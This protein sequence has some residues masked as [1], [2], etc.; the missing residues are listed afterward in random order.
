MNLD[1]AQKRTVADWIA[2]GQKLS[3]I[4]KRLADELDIHLTYVEVRMLV[5]DLKLMP[6]DPEPVKQAEL[7]GKSAS[8]GSTAL[9]P[10]TRSAVAGGARPPEGDLLSP[11]AG[12]V[13]VKVDQLARPDALVSG[14]VTFSDGH[15]AT[16]YL[17]QMGRL[18]LAPKQQGY[19]P[20]PPDL[21]AFQAELQNELA[22][23]G[24]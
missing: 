3:E 11:A 6:K 7:S 14:S 1:D 23:I 16:W 4:Q 19:K 2:N 22:K 12:K 8:L 24:F 5:D 10:E 17:D 15:S 20:S 9:V 21:Q 13:S 18:G